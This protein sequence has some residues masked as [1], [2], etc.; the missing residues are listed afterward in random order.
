MYIPHDPEE[1]KHVYAM[2]RKAVAKAEA[3]VPADRML[4]HHGWRL[5][6]STARGRQTHTTSE[7]SAHQELIAELGMTPTQ[8]RTEQDRPATHHPQ[9]EN[10]PSSRIDDVLMSQGL[11]TCKSPET[12]VIPGT[13]DSDHSALLAKVPLD[14]MM[15]LRPG[16]D[17]AALPIPSKLK[18]PVPAR[19]LAAFKEALAR[20]TREQ[21]AEL[22]AELE[23]TLRRA[24]DIK[25]DNPTSENLKELL[26]THDIHAELTEEMAKK[27]Q[28]IMS[29]VVPNAQKT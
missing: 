24:H 6:R 10:V 28:D 4:Q 12:Q 27:L 11:A 21:T 3:E 29:T 20:E 13:G 5:E 22:N 9:A 2:L 14:N 25:A 7:D 8:Q 19:Q 1:R 16:P 18:T 17:V 23:A 15:L 26:K